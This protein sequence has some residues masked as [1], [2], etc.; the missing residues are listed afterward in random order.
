M[1]Y[2]EVAQFMATTH[3]YSDVTDDQL[4]AMTVTHYMTV[5]N[6]TRFVGT[7][8]AVD[9]L[10]GQ[11]LIPAPVAPQADASTDATATDATAAPT[12]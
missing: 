5:L 3:I 7:Y 4:N 6:G 9:A 12:A 8:D 10:A 1:T 11:E 2:E